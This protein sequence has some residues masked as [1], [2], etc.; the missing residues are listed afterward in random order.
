M[1]IAVI[2]GGISGLGAA[3]RLVDNGHAVTVYEANDYV[4]GHSNTVD[5]TLD[6]ERFGVDTGFLVYNQRTYPNLIALFE[7][8][9]VP[10]AE[11][12]MSFAVSVGPHAFEWCGSNLRSLFAQPSNALSPRF[13]R[14]LADIA[15][16]NREATALAAT[17]T[18]GPPSATAVVTDGAA[19]GAGAR[20]AVASTDP[21]ASALHTPLGQWLDQRGYGRGFRDDYLLPMAAAIWSCPTRTML[22]FPLGSFVRFFANHGLLQVT[23]RPQWFTVRGGSREYVR[24]IVARLPDVRTR[25]AVQAVLRSRA[26]G[27]GPVD[28]VTAA[29]T[30][31][32][33]EVVLACHSDQ[34]LALLADPTQDERDV[35]GA[36]RY[37]P[38][39]AYLHTD[40]RLMPRRRGAW[41]AW[42][43]LSE[44]ASA[45]RADGRPE[46][47]VSVTYWLNRLQP[48]PCETPVLVS[49]NPLTPPDART[50]LR[51]FDYAHP[52]FDLE[53]GQAQRRLAGIQGLRHTW[54]AGAW[55][56][57]G[58]HEDGLRSGLEVA[59]AVHVSRAGIE[60]AAA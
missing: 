31:R 11:S 29:G 47:S 10:V 5:V 41:A 35:L 27:H 17:L 18:G 56:G 43:Y 24:R 6:G 49:L 51:T 58:F 40:T 39:R 20:V 50:V 1:K 45:S 46:P 32:F 30:E 52:V 33:D 34:A 55:A 38:N 48:L 21:Q 26:A 8:L 9:Q 60:R 4:G 59:D 36:I 23:D 19:A 3:L 25:S 28:V 54:F 13:W 2:G 14:M 42:N 15:R 7:R 57:Y 53:A 12:D 16:F 37:Q 44:G 22:E